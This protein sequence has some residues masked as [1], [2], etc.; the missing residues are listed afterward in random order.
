MLR[1]RGEGALR[2]RDQERMMVTDGIGP[3]RGQR[4][5]AVGEQSSDRSRDSSPSETTRSGP[6]WHTGSLQAHMVPF[7]ELEQAISSQWMKSARRGAWLHKLG[8]GW[9]ATRSHPLRHMP[10]RSTHITQR[11]TVARVQ[12]WA[13]FWRD[14][15]SATCMVKWSNFQKRNLAIDNQIYSTFY[16]L[17]YFGV[18]IPSKNS[19]LTRQIKQNPNL[20]DSK[21]F[22][23]A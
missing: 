17:L 19:F 2:E 8:A 5:S 1:G 6:V 9:I 16:F 15:I 12:L 18:Y 4:A 11:H 13:G 14:Q 21:M 22:R 23:I 7:W 3:R 20:I 10:W